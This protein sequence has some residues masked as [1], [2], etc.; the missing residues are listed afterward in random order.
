MRFVHI[1]M[2]VVFSSTAT[3]HEVFNEN[4]VFGSVE[5]SS[6]NANKNN[7]NMQ[8]GYKNWWAGYLTGTGVTFKKGKSP[9]YLPEGTN[10]ILSIGSFCQSNPESSLKMAIDSYINNQVK[11]GYAK[12]PNKP[13]KQD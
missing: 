8:F 4:Q 9:E 11:V 13:I 6:Y 7:P 2:F 5:C 1:L 3:E 12:L 10:F